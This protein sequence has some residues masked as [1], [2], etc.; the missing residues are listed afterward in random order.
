[1]DK[2]YHPSPPPAKNLK[3]VLTPSLL[4]LALLGWGW[5]LG[6]RPLAA[7]G[8]LLINLGPLVWLFTHRPE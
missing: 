2:A 3:D 1:L 7:V 5:F 4:G 6:L 8:L